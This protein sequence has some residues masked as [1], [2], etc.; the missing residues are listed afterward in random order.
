[1][2]QYADVR[3]TREGYD[4][5]AA[6]YHETFKH[7]L[8]DHPFHRAMIDAF[9]RRVKDT[10]GPV[11]DIGCGPG[12]VTAYMKGLGLDVRGLDLSPEMV[13]LARERHPGIDFALGDM[14]ELG[15]E[16]LGGVF[17]RSSII[18]TPPERIGA[19]LAGFHRALAPGGHLLLA[20]QAHT[21][22]GQLAWAFDHTVAPAYR[23][24]IPR[25]ADLL[26]TKGFTEHLRLIEQ[27]VE[28]PKRGF[29]YCHL[30]ATRD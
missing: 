15:L 11:A 17:S 7:S 2:E 24:S 27:P 22:D 29:H 4:A 16:G 21:D 25:I 5:F 12:H 6:E 1:M 26:R 23:W 3:T 13:A 18:H 30:V 14:N 10:G 20:F 9:A 19:V 28:D 8:D